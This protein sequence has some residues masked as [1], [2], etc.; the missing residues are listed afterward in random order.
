MKIKMLKK[1]ME[2]IMNKIHEK[3]EKF[4]WDRF[5]EFLELKN[6]ED[7]PYIHPAFVKIA[8][9]LAQDVIALMQPYHKE[10]EAKKDKAYHYAGYYSLVK[11]RNQYT[12]KWSR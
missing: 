8:C 12:K 6:S 3:T 4:K 10:I 5:E 1:Q 9:Q 11:G 2:E 7:P